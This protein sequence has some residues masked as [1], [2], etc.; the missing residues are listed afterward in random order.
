MTR[1]E[2]AKRFGLSGKK[3]VAPIFTYDT[4]TVSIVAGLYRMSRVFSGRR[5]DVRLD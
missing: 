2:G 3:R 4:S 5:Q 1:N